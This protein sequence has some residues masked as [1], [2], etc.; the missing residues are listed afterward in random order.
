MLTVV[1]DYVVQGAR[2]IAF[3]QYGCSKA[4]DASVVSLLLVDIWT[5]VIPFIS[6]TFYARKLH[7]SSRFTRLIKNPPQLGQCGY[8]T[9]SG[10]KWMSTSV[11]EPPVP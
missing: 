10:R 1:T 7:P 2:F 8:S 9:A 6:A 11:M 5:P 4:E 3:E